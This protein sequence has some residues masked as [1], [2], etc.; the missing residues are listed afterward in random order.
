MSEI[1]G[2]AAR[3]VWNVRNIRLGIREVWN[4]RNIRL[5]SKGSMEC[6]KY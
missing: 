5:G 4:V 2:W 1:L 6:E 3:E